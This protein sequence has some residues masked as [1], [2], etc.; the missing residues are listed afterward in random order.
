[1][2]LT[3]GALQ[4][5]IQSVMRAKLKYAR[6]DILLRPEIHSFHSLDFYQF[7]DILETAE[8]IKEHTKRELER[9]LR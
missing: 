5:A 8:P 9:L 7:A 2:D 1:M 4:I 3:V 6:P